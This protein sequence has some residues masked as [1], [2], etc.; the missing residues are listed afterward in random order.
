VTPVFQKTHERIGPLIARFGTLLRKK[1]QTL[2]EFCVKLHN[3]TQS[4]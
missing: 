1:I 3:I 4:S 2:R